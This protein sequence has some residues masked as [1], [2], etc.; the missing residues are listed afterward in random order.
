[1]VAVSIAIEMVIVDLNLDFLLFRLVLK[2]CGSD[3]RGY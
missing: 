1:M 3:R 2:A